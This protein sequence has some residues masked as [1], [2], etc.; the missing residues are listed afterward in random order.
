MPYIYD[1]KAIGR[2]SQEAARYLIKNDEYTARMAV[3]LWLSS[4]SHDHL[5][6]LL[7]FGTMMDVGWQDL[8]HR[9]I[10]DNGSEIGVLWMDGRY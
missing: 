5:I 1:G 3:K 2:N 6:D 7:A 9:G 10:E 8:V 4:F